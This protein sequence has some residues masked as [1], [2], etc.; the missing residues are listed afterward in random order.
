MLLYK[1]LIP[2]YPSSEFMGVAQKAA[3]AVGAE[4]RE[5]Q[6]GSHLYVEMHG[7][8]GNREA[9][10]VF[11][12]FNKALKYYDDLAHHSHTHQGFLITNGTALNDLQRRL[13]IPTTVPQE[14]PLVGKHVALIAGG[15]ALVGGLAYLLWPKSAAVAPAPQTNPQPTNPQTTPQ[16][17]QVTPS[18]LPLPVHLPFP[19]PPPPAPPLPVHLQFPTPPPPTPV[20]II[21]ANESG[22]AWTVKRNDA[23]PALLHLKLGGVVHG[24]PGQDAPYVWHVSQVPDPNVLAWTQTFGPQEFDYVVGPG[25]GLNASMAMADGSIATVLGQ[26]VLEFTGWVYAPSGK[27]VDAYTRTARFF[28]TVIA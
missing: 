12:A 11:Y 28:M 3:R 23:H 24:Q 1:R 10:R 14:N 2:Y 4:I 17:Q 7:E 26:T 13:G 9:G 27:V 25:Q 15:V 21:E 22:G 16:Q 20:Q 6:E 8:L 19:K 18:P 5:H